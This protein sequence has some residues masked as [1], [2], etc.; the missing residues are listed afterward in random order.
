M[1]FQLAGNIA[2]KASQRG[3]VFIVHIKIRD[4]NVFKSYAIVALGQVI[5]K[6]FFQ[7]Y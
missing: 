3:D 2:H 1:K 7:L 6:G 5:F 4:E